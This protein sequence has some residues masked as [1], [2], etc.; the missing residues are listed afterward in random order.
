MLPSSVLFGFVFSF[1]VV[2]DNS[3]KN[4]WGSYQVYICYSVDDRVNFFSYLSESTGQWHH[5]KHC[6]IYA[7]KNSGMFCKAQ[8]STAL[9]LDSIRILT[10]IYEGYESLM[11]NS[12]F[13]CKGEKNGE[14]CETLHSECCHNFERKLKNPRIS[15]S[16]SSVLTLNWW[17]SISNCRFKKHQLILLCYWLIW[18]YWWI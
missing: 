18:I 15:S 12:P 9:R 11:L 16:T 5:A 13:N 1:Q 3:Q 17:L 8:R 6:S 2:K 10:R 14:T 7:I 4:F